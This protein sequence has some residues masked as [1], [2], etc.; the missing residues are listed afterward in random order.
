MLHVSNEVSPSHSALYRIYRKLITKLMDN[1]S[2]TS[3]TCSQMD[4]SS[5]ESL[6]ERSART[7][8]LHHRHYRAASKRVRTIAQSYMNVARLTYENSVTPTQQFSN[9]I[10]STFYDYALVDFGSRPGLGGVFTYSGYYSTT[11]RVSIRIEGTNG[12]K[13][14]ILT[15][16]CAAS[17]VL[18]PT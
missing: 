11:N 14:H 7:R 2:A 6:S 18:L 1:R 8:C 5:Q 16:I 15:I 4:G 9:V 10:D 17:S 12:C 3:A 13:W